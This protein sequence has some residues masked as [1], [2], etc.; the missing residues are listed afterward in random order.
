MRR[1]NKFLIGFG[2]VL[3]F[4][5]CVILL[6]TQIIQAAA[7]KQTESMVKNLKEALPPVTAGMQDNYASMEMPSL[8]MDGNNI[9][10]LLE[11][12]AWDVSLPVGSGWDNGSLTAFPRR[13][14][15]TVYDGSLIIGGRDGKGQ[16]ACLTQVELG[17]VITVTDMTGA[18]F[19]YAVER[20]E[21]K[22]SAAAE[23]LADDT[24][25]LT[26][27]ARVAYSREYVIV[28]CTQQ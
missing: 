7:Q 4:C 19:T 9:I 1:R 24:A 13:F 27:F 17:D 22:K 21:R 14:S 23:V 15:G 5:S 12:P 2:F 11:I 28:R 26:L 6:V 25:D 20:V 8:E 16:F 18:C 3:I 10:A